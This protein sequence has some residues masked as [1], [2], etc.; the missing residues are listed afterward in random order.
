MRFWIKTCSVHQVLKIK[1]TTRQI[2]NQMLYNVLV[3]K[4]EYFHCVG[5][6]RES[7]RTSLDFESKLLQRVR[8]PIKSFQHVGTGIKTLRTCQISH[9]NTRNVIDRL[10]NKML[11]HVRFW[12][13][14]FESC[15]IWNKK[16]QNGSTFKKKILQS[17]YILSQ[18]V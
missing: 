7:F 12:I 5:F 16:I 9:Q 10:S 15:R 18:N 11:Q 6:Q 3:F 17:F 13:K 4:S 2:T 1:K 8:I 14:C